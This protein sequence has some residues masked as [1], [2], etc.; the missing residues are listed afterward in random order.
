MSLQIAAQHLASRGRGPDTQLMHMAP[1]E[2]AGLQALAKAHGGSL[3]INPDTGL[4]EA[5][6][7]SSI[8]PMV[9]GAGLMAAT[10]GAATPLIAGMSNA[11][12]IGLGTGAAAGL[13]TGSL[14]KGLMAGLGAYGGA[15]LA[16]GLMGAG[17]AGAGAG[18]GAGMGGAAANFGAADIA[19]TNAA[20]AQAAAPTAQTLAPSALDFVGMNGYPS[21]AS[22]LDELGY[23]AKNNL[24]AQI[25]ADMSAFPP[26][27]PINAAAISPTVT[28]PEYVPPAPT[29][30]APTPEPSFF[31]KF[32]GNA[33]SK[34]VKET[35]VG[36]L[37]GLAKYG[38]AAAAPL[39][40]AAFSPSAG[41]SLPA[42]NKLRP[43]DYTY[44]PGRVADPQ[45]G[46]T[47][48]E[49]GQRTY[50]NPTFT[51]TA[52]AGGMLTSDTPV[53]SLYAS[54]GI[55]TLGGYS[56]GG[57][58]LRGP[59]DGVSDSIPADIGGKQPARLADGEFVV[60]AR[61]VSELG[62]GSTEAGA[63]Q[64]Y[65]MLNRVQ[66]ARKK[67]MGKDKVA[68]NSKAANLLPA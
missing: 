61:I 35:G 29:A 33:A 21:P 50:F 56:D 48:A 34:G 20:L 59:G 57:Q 66:N 12:L 49:S 22:Y 60:P 38:G 41:G 28:P 43:F 36:G 23:A 2:V 25:P 64:L 27:S 13:A 18:A 9:V 51:R 6:I 17:A 58:L 5:G 52:A 63:K 14:S 65:A 26:V 62:N 1:G 55:S 42:A 31:N 53:N 39:L 11:A 15:G 67:S 68:A 45:A 30:V 44:N 10:G 46:Y 40:M 19:A 32:L 3:T 54:G 16:G 8:L 24:G 4:P 47:G 37:Y 7:L